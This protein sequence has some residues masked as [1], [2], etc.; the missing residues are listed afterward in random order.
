M[1]IHLLWYQAIFFFLRQLHRVTSGSF[2]AMEE[3]KKKSL[4]VAQM[5]HLHCQCIY[6]KCSPQLCSLVGKGN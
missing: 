3:V 5:V 4:R 6:Y 2:Q 1:Q